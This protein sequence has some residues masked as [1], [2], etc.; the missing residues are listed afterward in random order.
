M[1]LLVIKVRCVTRLENTNGDAAVSIRG[2]VMEEQPTTTGGSPR[3]RNPK[4]LSR[5]LRCPSK[6]LQWIPAFQTISYQAKFFF[7]FAA[8]ADVGSADDGSVPVFSAK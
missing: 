2:V 7:G 3:C 4:R 5:S 6:G 1:T 8:S